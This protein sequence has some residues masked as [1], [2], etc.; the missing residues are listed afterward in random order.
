M[1]KC[2]SCAYA[3]DLP[4]WCCPV[5]SW[6]PLI[7]DDFVLFSPKLAEENNLFDP[8]AFQS[9]YQAE[10]GNFWFR[11][12]NLI[13]VWLLKKHFASASNFM[14]VGAGTG[15]VLLGINRALPNLKL[16]GTEIFYQGLSIAKRR[17]TDQVTFYQMDARNIP[18]SSEF[19]VIGAFDCL[20]HIQEDELALAE[21]FRALKPGG[22]VIFNVPQ[23]P[24]MW[25]VEDERAYHKRRYSPK[26]LQ[27]KMVQAGFEIEYST[28]FV[29]VLLPLMFI[30][31]LMFNRRNEGNG[32]PTGL[33]IP[34]AINTILF[35]ISKI[36]IGLLKL[37]VRFPA[38]G[39]RLVIGRKK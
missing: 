11:C 16:T 2:L 27:K 33:Q 26:E 22:G 13:I 8:A 32:L 6:R 39:S 31:R 3:F 30:Q 36:E 14:E 25:S 7:K 5:C 20:E 29:S 4:E 18:F 12:R 37:G 19:D 21:I 17:L 34:K 1:K 10:A 38:G 9:L 24:F 28:S 23:H 35:A 15:Y